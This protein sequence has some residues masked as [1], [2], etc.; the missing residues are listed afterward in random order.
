M[1]ILINL[2]GTTVQGTEM[3]DHI[4]YVHLHSM[5]CTFCDGFTVI[6]RCFLCKRSKSPSFPQS[7][8]FQANSQF[9]IWTI[10]MCTPRAQ[11]A[12]HACNLSDNY[13]S[14]FTSFFFFCGSNGSIRQEKP[15]CYGWNCSM[16]DNNEPCDQEM[17]R[18][19]YEG[20]KKFRCG[21]L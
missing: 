20:G 11:T 21:I 18:L 16:Q 2:S 1:C 9:Q 10:G 13:N 3:R 5:K 6:A 17:L 4:I 14:R 19:R 15:L 12:V 7:L 8:Q